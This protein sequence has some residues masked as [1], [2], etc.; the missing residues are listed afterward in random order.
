MIPLLSFSVVTPVEFSSI[1]VNGEVKY[2]IV[3]RAC[4]EVYYLKGLV[5]ILIV[6]FVCALVANSGVMDLKNIRVG[7]SVT[8]KRSNGEAM[9]MFT[10]SIVGFLST[11]NILVNRRVAGIL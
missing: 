3:H 8:I 6:V 10:H 4:A 7:T 1:I 11:K 2:L 5:T 9:L